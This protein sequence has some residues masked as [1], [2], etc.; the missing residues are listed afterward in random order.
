[1][2][3][4]V[5]ASVFV[6]ASRTNEPFF[7]ESNRFLTEVQQSATQIVCPSL[8]LAECA[9]AIARSTQSPI[10]AT[11]II[12][13]IEAFPNISLMS[14]TIRL[15]REAA[16]LTS[17]L[18]LRGADAIYVALAARYAQGILVTWDKDKEMLQR[19]SAAVQAITPSDWLHQYSSSN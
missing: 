10:L 4:I 1:M 12:S 13:L 17:S 15:A 9:S 19:G 2:I 14:L 3:L 18:Q 8:V 5:D 6:A 7:V 16:Q 11:R